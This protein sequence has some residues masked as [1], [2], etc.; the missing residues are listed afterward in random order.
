MPPVPE[1]G[2]TPSAVGAAAPRREEIVDGMARKA[3]IL[4]DAGDP[5]LL[6]GRDQEISEKPARSSTYVIQAGDTPT[7]IAHTCG[8]SLVELKRMNPTLD[9]KRLKPGVRLRVGA[10]D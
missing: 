1:L 2:D 6:P 7:S 9:A 10:A 3:R 4:L 5:L 8:V